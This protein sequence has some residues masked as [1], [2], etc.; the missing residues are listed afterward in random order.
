MKQRT[1]SLAA[2]ALI[3]LCVVSASRWWAS[4]HDSRLGSAV[5][6]L[7][8]PGD[9]RM[10]SSTTCVYCARAREWMREH[11]VAF[12]ECFIETDSACAR[13]HAALRAMG[14]PLVLVRGQPQLGFDA[15]RVHD[16]LAALPAGGTAPATPG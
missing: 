13:Q 6:A 3:V 1:A 9:I 4:R 10:L 7:A 14:T 11:N 5:A 2:L 8:A 16:R 15:Q 12:D